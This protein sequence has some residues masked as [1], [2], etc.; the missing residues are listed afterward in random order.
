MSK[1]KSVLLFL[2]LTMI[3]WLSAQSNSEQKKAYLVADFAEN[4]LVTMLDLC[5]QGGFEY[6]VQRNPFSSYGHYEWNEDF[7]KNGEK[8]VV[9]MVQTAEKAGVHLGVLVQSDAISVDD[10]FF[11]P[12]YFKHLK[13]QGEVELY[14]AINA[15]VRD[16][17]LRRNDVVK[18]P[19]TLNLILIDDELI[20]YGTMEFAGEMVLL[21]RCTR[22]AYGTKNVPHSVDA[23]VYKI[24]DSPERYVEPD[25]HLREL[26]RKELTK[27]LNKVG[28]DFVLYKGDEGQEVLDE[29]IRVRQVERWENDGV[30][31]G[32]LGW[33]MLRTADKKRKNTT[34][35]D[36]EWMLSKAA[37]FDAGYGLVI[38]AKTVSDQGMLGE[39]FETMKRWNQ[40]T[41]DGAFTESQKELMKDPYIDWHLTEEDSVFLLYPIDVSRRFQCEF[42]EEDAGLLTA[43]KWEWTSDDGDRFGLRIMVEG[44]TEMRN[45]MVN[46][47]KGLVLFPCTI[48]PGQTL[49]YDFKDV[50]Y[51]MDA[52]YK[53][54]EEVNIE[55]MS[56]LPKGSSEVYLLCEADPEAE[57]PVVT[58]RYI[59]REKPEVIYPKK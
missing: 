32:S 24:W 55:G 10:P 29:S 15:D 41:K 1:R 33:I 50:A 14:D 47:E 35:E 31:N 4:Q 51:V 16:I 13:R 30:K 45:P 7:A 36:I 39:M 52:N 5:H 34:M 9:R 25:D 11:S 57:R 46:T 38:D 40:L 23:E 54:I 28:I 48:S 37:S 22:G 56:E 12:Q 44:N 19:S 21:H 58:V 53:T 49:V 2:C 27:R 18:A 42:I 59:T 43:D 8:S 20:S 26:V 3:G 6:L 17:T